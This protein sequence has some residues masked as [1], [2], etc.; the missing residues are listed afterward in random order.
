[1][2]TDSQDRR[3]EGEQKL[4]ELL[5]LSQRRAINNAYAS[6]QGQQTAET[7]AAFTFEEAVDAQIERIKGKDTQL[8]PNLL[9]RLERIRGELTQ[10]VAELKEIPPEQFLDMNAP[11]VTNTPS[12]A[13]D[14]FW[15][16]WWG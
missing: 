12:D 7:F 10:A 16:D 2:P 9:N 15:D 11:N 4:Q 5:H 8:H 14:E 1:M 13:D 3:E 6:L